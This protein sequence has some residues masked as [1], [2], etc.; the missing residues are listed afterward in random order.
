[1]WKVQSPA[2]QKGEILAV[3]PESVQPLQ[4]HTHTNFNPPSLLTPFDTKRN[5]DLYA[6]GNQPFTSHPTSLPLRCSILQ[7]DGLIGAGRM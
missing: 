1:M 2:A 6:L 3:T 5:E 7:D 4:G